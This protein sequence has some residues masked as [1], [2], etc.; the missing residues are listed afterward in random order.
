MGRDVASAVSPEL[1]VDLVSHPPARD[2]GAPFGI[3]LHVPF[4]ASRCGYCDFNTY[5]AGELGSATSTADWERAA[6]EE[7]DLAARALGREGPL[8]RIDTVFVGGGTPS[9]VGATVLGGLLGHLRDVFGLA[10]DAEVTTEA[11][12]EST[13]P[14]FFAELLAAGFTRVS[15][16]LQS[17]SSRVLA[18]LGRA[19][20]PARALA[21]AREAREAGFGHVNLDVI[22]GTPGETDDDLRR[23]LADVLDT[24]VDHVSAYSL[25]VEDGTAL[26]R[27]VRRGETPATDDD[28]FADRYEIVARTL[29]DVG[30]HWYEVS[31]FARSRAA[32]CRH[33]LGYWRDGDWWGLGPGAHSHVAGLRWWNHRHP[34][35]YASACDEGVLPVAGAEPLSEADRHLERVMLGLRLAEG[36]PDEE[37][38]PD[39]LRR[40]AARAAAGDL[41]RRD[42]GLPGGPGYALTE[43]GRLL[44]DGVVADVLAG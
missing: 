18:I 34:A 13:S 12:P 14:E 9:L 43:R 38:A 15:L 36:L 42:P 17:T 2:A 19:H 27:R 39:E 20:S 32:E 22:Y 1:A 11:N 10:P 26:A 25:I 8:P 16:G 29:G 5:T 3:Y 21:A 30:F 37:F 35:R 33:N 40:L 6:H 7:I 44:A 28:V 4:C 41:R 31:N 24:G 23:T